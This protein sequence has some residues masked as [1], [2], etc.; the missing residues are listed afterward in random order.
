M[1]NENG[2]VLKKVSIEKQ[3]IMDQLGLCSCFIE[4]QYKNGF[5]DI[6]LIN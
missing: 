5:L 3:G 6:Y 1:I 4:E 2:D